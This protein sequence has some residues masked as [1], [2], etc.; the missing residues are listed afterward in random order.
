MNVYLDNNATTMTAP[1][2]VEAMRAHWDEFYGNPSSVH[3]FGGRIR[4]DVARSR[5]QV[6]GLLG[7][8][9]DEIVFTSGG[10]EANNQAIRGTLETMA[11]R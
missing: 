1:E 3:R 10:S 5:E 8:S 7:A 9:A 6:A 2:V 4:K 11:G